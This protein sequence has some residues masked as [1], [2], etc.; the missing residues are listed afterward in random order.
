M[1]GTQHQ[2][3]ASP[4]SPLSHWHAQSWASWAL[5]PDGFPQAKV[6]LARQ[7]WS[8]GLPEYANGPAVARIT[9]PSRR[10]QIATQLSLTSA[11]RDAPLSAHSAHLKAVS[12]TVRRETP[13]AL[14]ACQAEAQPRRGRLSSA[15]PVRG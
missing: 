13:E 6:P 7:T 9:L 12:G 3:S 8:P 10:L 15:P 14:E 4:E 1:N 2:I 5:D 11:A